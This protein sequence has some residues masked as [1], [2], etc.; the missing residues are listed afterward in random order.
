[1]RAAAP[2]KETRQSLENEPMYEAERLRIIYQL[3]TNSEAEGGAGITP[4]EA[5]WKSVESIFALHDHA[6]N[7]QWIT[8]W[9]RQWLLSPEDLDDIR[10]RLGER[11]AYYFA[12][13]QS[14]FQFLI[15]LA[16][17]GVAAWLLLGKFSVFYAVVN[18]LACIVFTEWWKH[19]EVD[20]AV[21][22]GVRNVSSIATRNRDFAQ[23][24]TIT[25][26]VTGEQAAFF[27]AAKRLRRQFLQ[28]P[29]AVLCA[30]LLGSLIATCFGIEIFISEIYG[31]P[32]KSVLVSCSP[33]DFRRL[34]DACRCFCRRVS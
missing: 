2:A 22:W 26:P 27:P 3:I 5:S 31:G 19:Q 32:L 4:G 9:A 15:P 6:Y 11:I 25:D 16:G 8:K 34:S 23:E 13:T 10:N 33:Y 18:S 24:K 21:R 17:F 14:Y 30:V 12:F 1:M 7:K 29:F 20:L 28:L